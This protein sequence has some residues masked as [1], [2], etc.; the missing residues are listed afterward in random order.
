MN[1]WDITENTN[2]VVTFT[3]DVFVPDAN[4]LTVVSTYCQ[5][6]SETALVHFV[7]RK[8]NDSL[9]CMEFHVAVT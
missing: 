9:L 1:Q 2:K 5:H 6:R 3:S 4:L 8:K 7:K